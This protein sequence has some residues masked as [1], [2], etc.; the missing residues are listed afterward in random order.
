MSRARRGSWT[1]VAMMPPDPNVGRP[2]YVRVLAQFSEVP[3][4][5]LVTAWLDED[6][7]LDVEV[8]LR[9]NPYSAYVD[10]VRVDRV[11]P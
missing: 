7:T 3:H 2:R 8:A 1:A 6:G 9:P 5:V 4:E 11:Y 10:P